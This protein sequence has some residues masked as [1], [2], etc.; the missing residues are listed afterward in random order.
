M[1]KVRKARRS[2][3]SPD[4]PEPGV[5]YLGLLVPRH[6]YKRSCCLVNVSD[7]RVLQYASECRCIFALKRGRVFNE[8]PGELFR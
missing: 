4:T 7:L 6:V 1:A 5:K 8:K 3:C 2:R